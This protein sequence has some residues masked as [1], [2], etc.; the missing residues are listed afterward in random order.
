MEK[1]ILFVINHQFMW[2]T[3]A[4]VTKCQSGSNVKT[5]LTFLP[6]QTSI[7]VKKKR[8]I[9]TAKVCYLA[10]VLRASIRVFYR[11][12]AIKTL[13]QN[14]SGADV[15]GLS[16]HI[17]NIMRLSNCHIIIS[18]LMSPLLGYRPSLWITHK[19][20]VSYKCKYFYLVLRVT[21][22]PERRSVSSKSRCL[23]SGRAKQ[24][25]TCT[26]MID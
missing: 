9:T 14:G 20:N 21:P 10:K 11:T 23:S 15:F 24:P 2:K 18:L 1:D 8:M 19:E 17:P 6:R 16:Q 4:F 25:R 5:L 26:K 22:K 3:F 13:I 12:Q 7:E